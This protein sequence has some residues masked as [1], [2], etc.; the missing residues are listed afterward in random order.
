MK[1]SCKAWKKDLLWND[2]IAMLIDDT[3]ENTFDMHSC[4]VVHPPSVLGTTKVT[5]D[6]NIDIDKDNQ[7][8]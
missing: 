5:N 3:R 1:S 8:K 4:N 2:S 6:N 7:M